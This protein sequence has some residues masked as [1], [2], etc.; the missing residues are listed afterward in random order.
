VVK[1]LS[2]FKWNKSIGKLLV[3]F[4]PLAIMAQLNMYSKANLENYIISSVLSILAMVF[5][6]FELQ[7]RINIISSLKH[8]FNKNK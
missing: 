5:A 1:K 2:G 4:L 3:A 7:K 8:I 6:Y